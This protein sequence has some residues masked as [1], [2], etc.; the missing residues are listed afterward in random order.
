MNTRSIGFRLVSFYATL[1]S[2]VFVLLAWVMYFSMER[3]LENNL[4]DTLLRRA[5][6]I[7]ET[8]VGQIREKG[9]AYVADEIVARF[10]PETNARFIRLTEN[11]GRQV[12]LSGMPKDQSFDP[13]DVVPLAG[14]PARESV[15]QQPSSSGRSLLVA[16]VPYRTRDGGDFLIEVGSPLAPIGLFLKHLLVA[17][18]IV[19]PIVVAV[20]IGGG[21]FLVRQALGPVERITTSAEAITFHNLSQRLPATNTG[22]ELERLSLALNRMIARLDQSFQHTRRF[23]ADASHEL[24]TPLTIIRGELEDLVRNQDLPKEVSDSLGNIL[25]EAAHLN[26]IVEGLLAVAKIDAGD[27][28]QEWTPIDLSEL[29]SGTAEQMCL[30]GEDKGVSIQCDAS[31]P[32]MVQGDR[33][34]LKQVIVNLL[35]NAIKFTPAGGKIE[36]RIRARSGV[37]LIEVQDS[38]VGIPAELIHRVFDRFFRVDEARSREA[39]G[40]GIGLSI[41]KSIVSAHGG[42]VRA[43]SGPAGGTCFQVELP[44][45]TSSA[46]G[47]I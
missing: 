4:G 37:A 2:G 44:Q 45:K 38:G 14:M 18:L 5:H 12:Y 47:E 36:I 28:A 33:G 3:Y 24:R 10:A 42:T 9:R 7:A 34:R 22:D 21:F 26:R 35:D 15:R 29:A 25:E 43:E 46:Q 13:A 20:S 6:L 40:A 11:G 19:F 30:L 31:S 27:A 39:G 16:A 1:I 23:S 17:F 41:V 8:L 32:V